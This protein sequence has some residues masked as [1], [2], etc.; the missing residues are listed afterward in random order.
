M[1]KI[2]K[3]SL[4]S[5]SETRT[6]D[7]GKFEVVK[8]GGVNVGRATFQPGWKWSIS[9]KP[10]VKTESCQ[11]EHI[12]YMVSGRMMVVLDNG[13]EMEFGPND[14]GFVPPGHDAWVI[15]DEPVVYLD[16][17]AAEYYAKKS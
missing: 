13:S 10:L 4:N 6:F 16:F 9:V 14:A 8:F 2:E 7:N 1:K 12:I 15:G 3:M 17:T 5:P 11:A